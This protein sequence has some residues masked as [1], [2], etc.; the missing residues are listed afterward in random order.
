MKVQYHTDAL[1]GAVVRPVSKTSPKGEQ[2]GSFDSLLNRHSHFE[3]LAKENAKLQRELESLRI[4]KEHYKFLYNESHVV[5]VV[6]STTGRIL[7]V[8]RHGLATL[9]YSRDDVV[10]QPVLDFIAPSHR[11][12]IA[13]CFGRNHREKPA[14]GM[15]IPVY[16]KD[17]ILRVLVTSSRGE[18][19]YDNDQNVGIL[20]SGSDM[21]EP[22]IAR[23]QAEDFAARFK[24]VFDSIADAV[25]LS[26]PWG[27]LVET[28]PTFQTRYCGPGGSSFHSLWEWYTEYGLLCQDGKPVADRDRPF[29]TILRTGKPH[30]AEYRVA[31]KTDGKLEN[32]TIR[33]MPIYGKEKELL[34]VLL[35]LQDTTQRKLMEHRLKQQANDLIAANNEL[36]SFSYSVSHDLRAP[37]RTM[38]SFSDILQQD[39]G[40]EL[41]ETAQDFLRRIRVGADRMGELIDD[42]LKLSRISSQELHVSEVDL[43]QMAGDFLSELGSSAPDSYT[44]AVI[45]P[46]LTVWADSRLIQIALNNLIRN[47]WKFTRKSEH[48]RIEVGRLEDSE[49]FF[50]RDNGAGFDMTYSERLFTPFQR[51]HAQRDYPGTGIGLPIVRRVIVKHGGMIW[52][53]GK[54]G[55]GA[56]FY[57]TLPRRS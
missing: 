14:D 35:T 26:D 43:G 10:G 49:T 34:Y 28:N 37:L 11:D 4:A 50:V 8:N 47:A 24:A 44:E 19:V 23:R 25:A 7:D 17:G 9:G 21:T 39:Y 30:T 48:P 1:S 33:A 32:A 51:L 45:H 2:T 5:N 12:R 54:C 20:L 16:G 38:K 18:V 42:L 13:R 3:N 56:V 22:V 40:N 57:F 29:E 52:A 36:E 15:E 41:C 46:E 27:L 55:E 6:I 31:K 53:E